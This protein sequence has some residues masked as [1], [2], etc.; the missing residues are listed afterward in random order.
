M[1]WQSQL[2]QLQCRSGKAQIC[3]KIAQTGIETS[4]NMK[5]QWQLQQLQCQSGNGQR[6]HRQRK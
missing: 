2:Q 3:T 6:R 1:K 4:N 5:K